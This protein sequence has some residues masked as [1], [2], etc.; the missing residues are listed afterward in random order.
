MKAIILLADGKPNILWIQLW[1]LLF[2]FWGPTRI[3]FLHSTVM[4]VTPHTGWHVCQIPAIYQ[5]QLCG[6]AQC[7]SAFPVS[8]GCCVKKTVMLLWDNSCVCDRMSQAENPITRISSLLTR[9]LIWT[10]ILRV[11]LALLLKLELKNKKKQNEAES[12]KMLPVGR[13]VFLLIL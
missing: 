13:L 11:Q 7:L 6:R 4:N 12:S 1:R 5:T 10:E 9:Y 2:K 8:V 3:L